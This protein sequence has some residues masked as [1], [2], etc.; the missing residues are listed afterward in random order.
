MPSTYSHRLL[1]SHPMQL[2]ASP[3]G[4]RSPLGRSPS[5]WTSRVSTTAKVKYRET[6]VKM[7]ANAAA[8]RTPPGIVGR[9]PQKG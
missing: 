9:P 2:P 1:P 5:T 3:P 8:G 4:R 7:G 6:V